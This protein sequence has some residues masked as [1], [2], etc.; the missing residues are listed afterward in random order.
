MHA[1]RRRDLRGPAC[2]FSAAA[3]SWRWRA[4]ARMRSSIGIERRAGGGVAPGDGRSKV[5]ADRRADVNSDVG[6]DEVSDTT[7]D[8]V[9]KYVD[10]G[11]DGEDGGDVSGDAG[12]S[13]KEI[14]DDPLSSRAGTPGA[15]TSDHPLALNGVRC[16]HVRCHMKN[17]APCSFPSFYFKTR[18]T[19]WQCWGMIE[20]GNTVEEML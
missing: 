20:K 1:T 14:I 12:G 3:A 5:A 9:I 15:L 7:P 6:M 8:A 19:M 2:A 17:N 4:T 16:I 18:R 10:I 13:P 11:G